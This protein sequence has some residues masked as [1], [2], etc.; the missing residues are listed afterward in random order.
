MIAAFKPK[1][2]PFTFQLRRNPRHKGHGRLLETFVFD[3]ACHQVEDCLKALIRLYR[4][5]RIRPPKHDFEPSNP[6][7]KLSHDGLDFVSG[8]L[9]HL[10][11]DDPM[12]LPGGLYGIGNMMAF[13]ESS[14]ETIMFGEHVELSYQSSAP[15]LNA[16][17][18]GSPVPMGG[19]PEVESTPDLQE[20][21][22][23]SGQ[24]PPGPVEQPVVSAPQEKKEQHAHLDPGWLRVLLVLC[25]LLV[26][27]GYLFDKM[28]LY[29]TLALQANLC[30]WRNRRPNC[31]LA[32][33]TEGADP[34]G[35]L[36][37]GLPQSLYDS[38]NH[39]P[40]FEA[41]VPESGQDAG[42]EPGILGALPYPANRGYREDT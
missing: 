21:P 3:S 25:C 8:T 38:R 42:P 15:D 33:Q 19:I 16:T 40:Q 13:D 12:N 41:V 28:N 23:F 24:V 31:G 20:P 1:T 32:A 36:L 9:I 39:I 22:A 4:L 17:V 34:C 26:L 5:Q 11:D 6:P 2:N 35:Q 10:K 27:G 37:L 7:V 14:G 18:I 29:C 30:A